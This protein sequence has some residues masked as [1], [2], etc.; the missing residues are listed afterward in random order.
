MKNALVDH[1]TNKDIIS[2]GLF[3]YLAEFRKPRAFSND[4]IYAG[5]LQK[6]DWIEHVSFENQIKIFKNIDPNI[7]PK[8]LPNG[9]G[10][11][12]DSGKYQEYQK[13]NSPH[14]LSLYLAAN[15]PV[16]AWK[17]SAIAPIVKT[18]RLGYL[19]DSIDEIPEILS[20]HDDA[21]YENLYGHIKDFGKKVRKGN[22]TKI[23]LNRIL[24][25]LV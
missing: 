25:K 7:L 5:T 1:G 18:Q 3:D 23:V 12:Y 13:I 24:D 22:Y 20:R 14:K 2:I 10:I 17:Q 16:L 15:L 21:E 19:F 11:I 8:T 9:F 6:A 4:L